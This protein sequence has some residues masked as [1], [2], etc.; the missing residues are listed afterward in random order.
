ML[1]R[2]DENARTVL[3]RARDEARALGRECIGTEH[4]LLGVCHHDAGDSDPV[5]APAGITTQSVRAWLAQHGGQP[6][7]APD[8]SLPF[9]PNAWSVLDRAHVEACGRQHQSI[10][11]AHV[12]LALIR[13]A[14]V[15]P[16]AVTPA[17]RAPQAPPE[18]ASEPVLP[19][20][21]PP[22]TGHQPVQDSPADPDVVAALLR[23]CHIDL[24]ALHARAAARANTDSAGQ[25]FPFLGE[26]L[27]AC[28][29]LPGGGR[30]WLWR[31][32]VLAG[33]APFAALEI[34]LAP[35]AA[36]AIALAA[37]VIAPMVLYLVIG[38][39]ARPLWRRRVAREDVEP[40]EA[41]GLRAALA[42]AG[43]REVT[44]FCDPRGRFTRSR[45]AARRF[46]RV[47]MIFLRPSLKKAHSDLT[48]FITAHEAAHLARD[49]VM[50]EGLAQA[51]LAT[52]LGVAAATRWTDVLWLYLPASALI[53]TL[54]WCQ[55]LACDRIAV[56]AAG[57]I[58][59]NEYI[60]YLSR[61]DAR[62]RSRPF[63]P[64]I[65]AQ[66]RGWLTH[67]PH[68]MRRS[69]LARTIAK[70]SP[71]SLWREPGLGQRLDRVLVAGLDERHAAP[72]VQAAEPGHGWA[73]QQVDAI[74]VQ[75]GVPVADLGQPGRTVRDR[76]RDRALGQPIG[77]NGV[78]QLPL[79]DIGV[80]PEDRTGPRQLL[81]QPGGYQRGR[82]GVVAGATTSG[83]HVKAADRA[84]QDSMC[85]CTPSLPEP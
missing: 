57:P 13:C 1:E 72:E 62:R 47:G 52:L 59:A 67:P 30:R 2:F 9:T 3:A 42:P 48:R 69:A 32:A 82:A 34:V 29:C 80:Q 19:G 81:G 85:S 27:A 15:A 61:A 45:G 26:D 83:G 79:D 63:L 66:L 21:G 20:T 8:G 40:I 23:D 7:A 16:K 37:A 58:P 31:A 75:G 53:V 41:P 46:G 56:N 84:A 17:A 60:A 33:Y 14:I 22:E 24:R 43:L 70:A 25:G 55:E 71:A 73:K 68:R 76:G 35:P 6:G 39:V 78:G 10:G 4:V 38:A 49:D 50:S 64:R 44:V 77:L 12:L 5:L 28:P 65:R 36:R 51:C 54:R 74:V 18:D 11:P